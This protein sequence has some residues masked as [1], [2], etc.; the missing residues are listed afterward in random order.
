MTRLAPAQEWWT[1][2]EIAA[3]AL[4]D[5]PTTHQ[6]ITSAA[7]RQNWRGHS[8]L[9][10]RRAG[11]GGGWEYHWTLFPARAQTRLLAAVK[12]ASLSPPPAQ[13]APDR[14]AAWAWFDTLPETVKTKASARLRIIQL[15]EALELGGSTRHLAVIDAAR[16]E[17]VAPRSIWNWYDM[18]WGIRIDDRLAYLAPRH[19]AAQRR[20]RRSVIDPRFGDLIKADVLRLGEPSL[21]SCY[22]RCVRI[23]KAEGLPVAPL[24]NV[25]RWL[26]R[27]ISRTTTCRPGRGSQR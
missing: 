5:M 21:T 24:H 15:V 4:P 9:A 6:N 26:D 27:T 18:I 3:A 8:K 25:R 22:D 19:R 13:A 1:A 16:M 7:I 23:A 20:S 14:D 17:Q 10:R 11:K 12:P 2:A